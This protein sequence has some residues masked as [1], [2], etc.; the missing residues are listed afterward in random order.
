MVDFDLSILSEGLTRCWCL[1]NDFGAP[2]LSSNPRPFIEN[3]GGVCVGIVM[4]SPIRVI[5]LFVV[6]SLI[7]VDSLIVVFHLMIL[8]SRI[9]MTFLIILSSLIDASCVI[10]VIC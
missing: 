6:I 2:Q 1:L 9:V 10:V 5:P 3:G 7:V 4:I 8:I